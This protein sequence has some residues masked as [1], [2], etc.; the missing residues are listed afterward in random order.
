MCVIKTIPFVIKVKIPIQR[1]K[2]FHLTVNKYQLQNK[3]TLRA[4]L[5]IFLQSATCTRCKSQIFYSSQG[6]TISCKINSS[7][8]NPKYEKIMMDFMPISLLCGFLTLG[9]TFSFKKIISCLHRYRWKK[10]FQI[11]EKTCL[12]TNVGVIWR[13]SIFFPQKKTFRL[14]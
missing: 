2:H 12:K 14:D 9:F 11:F 3:K 7:H 10:N 1:R 5:Q 8:G 13:V 6:F 4:E